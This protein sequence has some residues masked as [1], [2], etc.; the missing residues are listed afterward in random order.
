MHSGFLCS[1]ARF[2][3][4]ESVGHFHILVRVVAPPRSMFFKK[5]IESSLCQQKQPTPSPA[6]PAGRPAGRRSTFQVRLS[7]ARQRKLEAIAAA[8]EE[9]YAKYADIYK[10]LAAERY[11]RAIDASRCERGGLEAYR[12]RVVAASTDAD[13]YRGYVETSTPRDDE[14]EKGEEKEEEESD[15]GSGPLLLEDGGSMPSDFFASSSNGEGSGGSGTGVARGESTTAVGKGGGSVVDDGPTQVGLGDGAGAPK[16]SAA[17]ALGVGG[18]VEGGYAPAATKKGRVGG[19]GGGGGGRSSFVD[20]VPFNN[21]RAKY[22]RPVD[23]TSLS[24]PYH[25]APSPG[26]RAESTGAAGSR[27]LGSSMCGSSTPASA[28]NAGPSIIVAA[29]ER[30]M[31]AYRKTKQRDRGAHRRPGKTLNR[32]ERREWGAH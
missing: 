17:L 29:N 18:F 14:G 15:R 20:V 24:R 16:G 22:L 19:D 9:A 25:V 23:D 26:W 2:P 8:R 12:R 30:T 4:F 5:R 7:A 1:E 31:E 10:D 28:N 32:K 13:R 11:A 21:I 27:S 6:R 3:G